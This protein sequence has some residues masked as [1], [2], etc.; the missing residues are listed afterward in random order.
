MSEWRYIVQALPSGEW[1]EWDLPLTNVE[2]TQE[3]SGPGGL[4]GSVPVEVARLKGADGSPLL[5]PWGCAIWAEA[6][7]EIRGGGL[8]V[9]SEFN[10]AS[11]SLECVGL[12]GYANGQP[13]TAKEYKGIQVDP[14]SIVRRIWNH[15]QSQPG[16]NLG[17]V[18]DS[19]TSPVRIG[20]ES[21]DVEFTTGAGQDV[22]F[23]AGPFKLNAWSTADVGKVV[24]DLA[25]A[26]PFDY[27]T[28]TR[29]D[30]EQLAHR[31]ELAYPRRG[32]RRTDMRFVVGENVTVEP[33]QVMDGD[34]YA[35]EVLALGAGEGSEMVR[36]SVSARRQGLR[37][38]LSVAD[39]SAR[40]KRAA[41]DVARREL[42]WRSADVVVE[43]L[44]VRQSALAE[45]HAIRPGDEVFFQ[46]DVGW[47]DVAMWVR[48][49]AVSTFPE[50]LSTVALR[51]ARSETVVA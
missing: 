41:T 38:A 35:T 49:L 23:E 34:E 25:A 17:L 7:G 32:S 15:L 40:S 51:V 20:T 14:L 8:L 42:A 10:G 31:L 2:I 22:A 18:V 39:K 36:A 48:V 26:T 5:T 37:R 30:G 1:L 45:V 6:S 27:L 50:D 3:L 19:T 43:E 28:H 46:S 4:S 11:W 24:D 13:W 47:L 29:W 44:R 9:R 12:S 33:A 16:G 21:E